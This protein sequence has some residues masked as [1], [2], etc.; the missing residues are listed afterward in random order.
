MLS[1]LKVGLIELLIKMVNPLTGMY[2]INIV[3]ACHLTNTFFIV[4]EMQFAWLQLQFAMVHP[5]V[6]SANL[7]T[8][9]DSRRDRYCVWSTNS[10]TLQTLALA[11]SYISKSVV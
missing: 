11:S 3:A 1:E 2:C 8:V 5:G 7:R 10:N 4:V 9:L 6:Q